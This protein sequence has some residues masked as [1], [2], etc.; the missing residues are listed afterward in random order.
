[1]EIRFITLQRALK[2]QERLVDEHGGEHGVR[3][4]N[5]LQS[6][7]HMPTA[8]FDN[9]FLHTDLYEM[10]GAYMYH[11]V[12][13]HPFVDGNKR[14]GSLAAIIFLKMNGVEFVASNKV[15]ADFTLELA[16]GNKDKSEAAIF[17]KQNS[18]K[19]D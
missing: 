17:F 6:A 12:K 19:A 3:D 7:L 4:M 18:K 15:L 8:T 14:A 2:M 16:S 1:M 9:I 13:N 10:A 11:L 5:L